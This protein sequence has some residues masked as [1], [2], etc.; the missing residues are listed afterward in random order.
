IDGFGDLAAYLRSAIRDDAPL[1][2]RDGGVI[3]DGFNAELD[4][5]R[6]LDTNGQRWL[7]E[8][9]AAESARTGISSLK[10]GYNRVFGYYIEV[11][12]AHKEKVPPEYVRRQTV[13]NAER[14]ITDEL[15][16]HETEAL[17]DRERS[18]RLEVELFDQVCRRIVQELERLQS[19]AAAI[20]TLD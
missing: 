15:K 19:A 9:Q 14:Y 16:R 13:R 11:T 17:T 1:V 8:Y 10:V 2:A 18:A 12:N 7:A 5:L 3:A 6:A 20:A 4:R